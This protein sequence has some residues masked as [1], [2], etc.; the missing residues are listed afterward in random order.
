MTFCLRK[1]PR[2]WSAN[3]EERMRVR[4]TGGPNLYGWV[5][6]ILGV[7]WAIGWHWQGC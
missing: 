5:G 2:M 1:I 7:A 3:Q 6:I 4:I